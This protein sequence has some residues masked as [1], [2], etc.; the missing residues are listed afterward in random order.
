MALSAREGVFNPRAKRVLLHPAKE[1]TSS[2]AGSWPAVAP[3]RSLAAVAIKR[4]L[5]DDCQQSRPIPTGPRY[6][7]AP[8]S[9]NCGVVS[10][11][12]PKR[13]LLTVGVRRLMH[14][15]NCRYLPR[16]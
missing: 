4:S 13:R 10:D 6:A 9:R 3:K 1:V 12:C 8:P 7:L 15:A 2:L 11:L 16:S 14:E 5:D